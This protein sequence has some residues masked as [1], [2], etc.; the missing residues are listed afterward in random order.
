MREGEIGFES[1]DLEGQWRFFLESYFKKN[2][3]EMKRFLHWVL[4]NP[5]YV[6]RSESKEQ[7]SYDFVDD[8]LQNTFIRLL[9]E[10]DLF[11]KNMLTSDNAYQVSAITRQLR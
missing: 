4:N 5:H 6:R 7:Q 9:N 3:A 11:K 8:I 2:K 10:T 1:N